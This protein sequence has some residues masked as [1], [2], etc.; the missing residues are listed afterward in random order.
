MGGGAITTKCREGSQ[1]VE[2]PSMHLQLLFCCDSVPLRPILNIDCIQ[3]VSNFSSEWNEGD[4]KYRQDFFHIVP[5]IGLW[6]LQNMMFIFDIGVNLDQFWQKE[7][8]EVGQV[9]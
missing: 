9:L 3:L 8:I 4:N 2:A 1:E 5:S 6:P 7:M